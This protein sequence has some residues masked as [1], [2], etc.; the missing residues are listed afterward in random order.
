MKV[1]AMFWPAYSEFGKNGGLVRWDDIAAMAQAAERTGWDSYW[2][3]DHLLF[4]MAMGEAGQWEAFTFL[5]ALAASTSRIQLGPLVTAIP[6]RNP[7]LL[8]KMADSIDEISGGRF[9]LAVGAGWHEPEFRAF[10]YPYDHL[11]SR[12]EEA[13]QVLVPLLREGHADFSGRYARA[14]NAV[15]RPRGPS[16]SGPP[17]WIGSS[18]PRMMRIAARY[19]DA[20][21]TAWHTDPQAL[22]AKRDELHRICEEVGRDPTTIALT[23]GAAVRL[24]APGETTGPSLAPKA[25]E[26]EP[27]QVAEVLRA[28]A[29]VGVRHLVVIPEPF[30][31]ATLERFGEVLR[32][33]DQ[34]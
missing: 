8:A 4:R 25:I 14:E 7:G 27:E 32:L 31:M 19:A 28:F 5:A 11:A 6:F 17:L 33:L 2:L 3:A 22:A 10:G 18:G 26:G 16:K 34:P 9:I 23:A 30:G 20:W 1:G 21:N 29:D 15:L 24:R 12:F 13:L